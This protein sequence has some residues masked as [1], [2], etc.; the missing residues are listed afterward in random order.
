[1]C[2]HRQKQ[3]ARRLYSGENGGAILREME[4]HFGTDGSLR[5]N[6]S[7][8]RRIYMEMVSTDVAGTSVSNGTHP[9]YLPAIRRLRRIAD[10]LP[11]DSSCRQKLQ[12]FLDEPLYR[13]HAILRKHAQRKFCFASSQVDA[14]FGTFH[15]LPENVE[16]IRITSDT[17]RRCEEMAVY[18]RL[19]KNEEMITVAGD[20]MLGKITGMLGDATRLTL[21]ELI[22]A[23]CGASGRRFTEVASPR[24]TFEPMDGVEYGARFGGQL[25]THEGKVYAI[26]LLVRWKLFERA[27]R[28]LRTMQGA[29]VRALSNREL[30]RRYQGNA[31]REIDRSFAPLSRPH[32]LRACYAAMVHAAFDWGKAKPTFNRIAMQV[33]GHASLEQSL[34]YNTIHLERFTARL[35]PFALAGHGHG[36]QRQR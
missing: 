11:A 36:G 8:L 30:S 34:A 7:K 28:H 4:A 27:L 21:S 26:P 6:V 33:L 16:A 12:H 23:L 5:S 20:A 19:Q 22:L 14:I 25:K 10:A 2:S 29:E 13:Q 1:M 17:H 32:D 31:S 18:S 9:T 15:V 35:G 3:W 24:S